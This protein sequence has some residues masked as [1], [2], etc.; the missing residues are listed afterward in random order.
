MI[1]IFSAMLKLQLENEGSARRLD[2]DFVIFTSID[3]QLRGKELEPVEEE[4]GKT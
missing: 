1:L 3:R 2:E 4:R